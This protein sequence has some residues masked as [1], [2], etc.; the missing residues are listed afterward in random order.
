MKTKKLV[1]I[2]SILL[3]IVI[4]E[5]SNYYISTDGVNFVE[6]EEYVK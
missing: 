4:A 3:I 2:A 5:L 1:I 6:M